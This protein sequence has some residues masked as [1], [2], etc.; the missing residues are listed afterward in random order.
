MEIES[1]KED[2]PFNTDCLSKASLRKFQMYFFNKIFQ[3]RRKRRSRRSNKEEIQLPPTRLQTN[4]GQI[5]K[6]EKR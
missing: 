3:S 4:C 2:I 6:I 1:E 5:L